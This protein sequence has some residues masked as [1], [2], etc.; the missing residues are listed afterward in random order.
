MTT[1]IEI[2]KLVDNGSKSGELISENFKYTSTSMT[3]YGVGIGWYPSFFMNVPPINADVP[4]LPQFKITDA[5]F[6]SFASSLQKCTHKNKSKYYFSQFAIIAEDET[7]RNNAIGYFE[8]YVFANNHFPSNY[9]ATGF[10]SQETMFK[11]YAN[12][13]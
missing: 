12:D 9:T 1:F 5:E 11:A 4:G 7:V 6:Q 10:E 8:N 13:E 2:Q 3:N